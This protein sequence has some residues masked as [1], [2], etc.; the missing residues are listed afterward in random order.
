MIMI[1]GNYHTPQKLSAE[2]LYGD[3]HS[4]TTMQDIV[5]KKGKKGKN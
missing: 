2:S 1:L 3:T 5:S 4:V